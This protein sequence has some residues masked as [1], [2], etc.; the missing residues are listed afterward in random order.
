MKY[1]L[2]LIKFWSF[3]QSAKN[4]RYYWLKMPNKDW[5]LRVM[6]DNHVPVVD[7]CLPTKNACREE[8]LNRQHSYTQMEIWETWPRPEPS[9]LVVGAQIYYFY[10]G[11][12]Y[13]GYY[14]VY[15][16]TQK[17]LDC[18]S[19]NPR[20]ID[21]IWARIHPQKIQINPNLPIYKNPPAPPE[22]T[23]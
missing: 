15:T 2:N 1:I 11:F 3:F 13:G 17:D 19:T 8:F 9:D 4:T 12:K 20:Y 6:R 18:L 10:G 16:L 21:P 14:D 7:I 22:R 5:C 23:K